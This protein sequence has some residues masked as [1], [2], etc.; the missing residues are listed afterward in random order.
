MIKKLYILFTILISFILIFSSETDSSIY[1][2]TKK[3]NYTISSYYGYRTLNYYHFHNGI[4]IPLVRG[5]PLYPIS[6]GTVTFV[7]YIKGYGNSIIITYSNGYKT[8]YGHIDEKFISS[9]GDTVTPNTVVAYVGPKYLSNGKLNGMTTGP[10]LHYTLY[11]NGKHIN[12]LNIKY[13]T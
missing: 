11:K 4:D 7:G 9:V 2:P 8:L 1:F 12:P 5:T 6:H 3:K 13:S 10:H